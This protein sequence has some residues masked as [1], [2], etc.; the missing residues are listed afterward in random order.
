M[1]RRKVDL[2]ESGN[3][4]RGLVLMSAIAGT[5]GAY[6]P[7]QQ[8][9]TPTGVTQELAAS[10]D[11][12]GLTG[13][14]Q[15]K[16]VNEPSI[17]VGPASA[18]AVHMTGI[19]PQPPILVSLGYAFFD[20]GTSAWQRGL[21]PGIDVTCNPEIPADAERFYVD[22]TT[23]YDS[24]NNDYLVACMFKRGGGAPGSVKPT[25]IM[26]IRFDPDTIDDPATLRDER[27]SCW[28]VLSWGLQPPLK[29]DKPVMI[30]GGPGEFYITW[31]NVV[32]GANFEYRRTTTSGRVNPSDPSTWS[33]SAWSGGVI[34]DASAPSQPITWATT[35]ITAYTIQPNA[36][37]ASRLYLGYYYTP[38]QIRFLAGRDGATG[39]VTFWRL[40][41][42]SQGTI[43]LVIDLNRDIDAPPIPK[44]VG[45]PVLWPGGVE[46]VVDSTDHDRFYIAY[47]DTSAPADTESRVYVRK[48]EYSPLGWQLGPAIQIS[49]NG[50]GVTCPGSGPDV[51]SDSVLPSIAVDGR[52]RVI[53]GYYQD[54]AYCQQDELNV[55]TLRFDYTL[56]FLCDPASSSPLIHRQAFTSL[57]AGEGFLDLSVDTG[58]KGALHYNKIA[59][60]PSVAGPQI[61]AAAI[62][63][64]SC[65]VI[66]GDRSALY[67]LRA[68][69]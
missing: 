51:E 69:W 41:A 16:Y 44:V 65:P 1:I 24:S 4:V 54:R 40:F 8:C 53:V 11:G 59:I 23:A 21:L 19:V 27:F 47:H 38:K 29:V 32:P 68:T 7:P 52:G 22:V 60:I 15:N 67:V 10:G 26:V 64:N 34:T 55:S 20:A 35:N 62:G 49:E 3:L 2:S 61:W 46:L 58:Q 6:E 12:L 28:A 37:G 5:S 66:E 36:V 42:D 31:T 25:G 50:L 18:F 30:A 48:A 56:A 13:P 45:N 33:A 14:E 17:A 63:T 39:G 9:L 57:C 43:P